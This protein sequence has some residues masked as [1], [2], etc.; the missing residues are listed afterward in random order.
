MGYRPWGRKELDAT[1]QLNYKS[2]SVCLLPWPPDD[3]K[4]IPHIIPSLVLVCSVTSVASD[5]LQLYGRSPPG[6][7]G[8][9]SLQARIL[10]WVGISSSRGSSRPRDRT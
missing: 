8:H 3:S 9:G 10:E 7:S 2:C 4:H 6:S 1:E 5:S